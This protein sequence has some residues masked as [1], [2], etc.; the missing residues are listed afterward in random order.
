MCKLGLSNSDPTREPD[1]NPTEV[2]ERDTN[3]DLN[4]TDFDLKSTQIDRLA[5][6]HVIF[7]F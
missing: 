6:K 4:R 3:P 7:Q 2:T 5:H 1:P